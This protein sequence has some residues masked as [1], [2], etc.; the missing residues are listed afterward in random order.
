MLFK[1]TTNSKTKTELLIFLT[2]HVAMDPR[3]LKGMTDDENRGLKL[4]PN[5]VQPGTF[6]QQMQ[7]MER[8]ATT[9]QPVNEIRIQGGQISSPPTTQR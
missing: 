4:V 2:P 5:S 1:D 8:G 9:T 7:G 6:E 3:D